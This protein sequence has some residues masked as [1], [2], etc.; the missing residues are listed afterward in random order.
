MARNPDLRSFETEQLNAFVPRPLNARLDALVEL[1]NKAGE[2]TNRREVLCALILDSSERGDQ[3]AD[4]VRTFRRAKA[5]DAVV[6]GFDQ[7][8]FLQPRK[9]GPG[10]RPRGKS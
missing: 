2:N 10:P 5:Q 1:A 9:R 3:L 4:Q 7:S 8:L 6:S